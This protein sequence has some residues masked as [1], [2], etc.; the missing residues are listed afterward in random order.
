MVGVDGGGV[1]K[2][3]SEGVSRGGL[4][5]GVGRRLVEP[6]GETGGEHLVS[7]AGQFLFD[8]SHWRVGKQRDIG[9]RSGDEGVRTSIRWSKQKHC[10][11]Q[12]TFL[13]LVA[14]SKLYRG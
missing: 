2:H 8:D 1:G 6:E 5:G 13:G 7:H 14:G 4:L 10:L 3:F 11:Q 12:R 9:V